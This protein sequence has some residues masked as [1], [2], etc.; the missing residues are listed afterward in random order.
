MHTSLSRTIQ[1]ALD[2][3]SDTVNYLPHYADHPE[4]MELMVQHMIDQWD[5]AQ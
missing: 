3:M 5:F 2:V 4:V 1:K